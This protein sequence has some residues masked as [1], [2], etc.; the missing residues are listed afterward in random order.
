[1]S[2]C[3][4]CYHD[5]LYTL[6]NGYQKCAK[7]KRK[8]SPKKIDLEKQIIEAFCASKSAFAFAKEENRSYE[9]IY[10]IYNKLRLKI[11]QESEHNFL[12]Q[13]DNVHEYEEYIYMPR[14][15]KNDPNALYESH[16][17]MI[18]DYKGKIYTTLI[19]IENRYTPQNIDRIALKKIFTSQKIAKTKSYEN[20]ITKFIEFFEL[21]IRRFRGVSKEKFFYYLK[22]CEFLFNYDIKQR[23]EILER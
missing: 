18:F 19:R 23:R 16:N 2:L 15:K 6:A 3:I 22:E 12:K 14:Y 8:F 13:M 21:E 11:A 1:M 9:K 20:K 7:C 5:K 4:Y 10:K 17:I